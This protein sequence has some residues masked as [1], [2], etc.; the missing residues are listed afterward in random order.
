MLRNTMNPWLTGG[1]IDVRRSSDKN[2]RMFGREKAN[3]MP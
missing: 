3:P 2:R 1:L